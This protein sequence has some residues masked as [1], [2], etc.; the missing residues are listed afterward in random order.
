MLG[1]QNKSIGGNFLSNMQQAP[2]NN[3]FGQ[4]GANNTFGNKTNT[5]L[6]IFNTNTTQNTNQPNMF[7][8]TAQQ[9]QTNSFFTQPQPQ[10]QQQPQGL[11]LGLLNRAPTTNTLG[12]FNQ[13][14]NTTP[15]VGTGFLNQAP[16][17]TNP[18]SFM[19]Q[20]NTTPQVGAG[21]L[22]QPPATTTLGSFLNQGNTPFNQPNQTQ[23]TGFLGNT[24]MQPTNI[25]QLPLMT[26]YQTFPNV[27]LSEAHMQH[28]RNAPIEQR[29]QFI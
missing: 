5:G 20:G 23:P 4:P 11:G 3:V 28:I 15:Q 19:N 7:T 17:T 24:A 26:S 8:N 16:S 27:P 21:F 9:P 14:Q 13:T 6:G 10:Q 22:N 18:A 1:N 12:L 25:P 29:K 2:Q